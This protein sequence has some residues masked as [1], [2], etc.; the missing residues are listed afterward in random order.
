M[1]WREKCMTPT[2]RLA[3]GGWLQVLDKGQVA[4]FGSHHELME[5]GGLYARMW[6]RQVR[7]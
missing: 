7:T 4:A 5:E 2:W 1:P 6:S 3:V